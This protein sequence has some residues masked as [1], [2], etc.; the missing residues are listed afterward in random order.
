MVA[1]AAQ[2]LGAF[3]VSM[4]LGTASTLRASASSVS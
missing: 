4:V 3:R 1:A 2:T